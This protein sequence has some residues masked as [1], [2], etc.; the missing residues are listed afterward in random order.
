MDDAGERKT[1][2]A[3][4]DLLDAGRAAALESF[5]ESLG[6][7]ETARAVARL[8]EENREKLF[9]LL[10]PDEAAA[11]ILDLP[12]AQAAEVIEDM[13][14]QSA[15]LIV[16]HLPDNERADVLGDIPEGSA[17]AI[18]DRM[19]TKDAAEARTLMDYPDNTAGGLMTR[20]YLAYGE[21]MTAADVVA[22][23]RAQRDR[24]ASHD[25][26][27]IYVLAPGGRLAG[28]LRLRDLLLARPERAIG[29]AM[30][31]T[32]VA[33]PADA[34][35]ESVHALLHDQG[36]LGLP[37][38]DRQGQLLGV[39]S[40][41]KL[42]EAE[43]Q[44][45]QHAMLAMSG[46]VGGEEL[47]SMPLRR[48]AGKRLAWLSL[49]VLL[50]I[51]AASVIAVYQ[52]TLSAAVVLAVFL[53]IISD[54]SGCSGNQAAAVSIREL[55][56]GLVRPGE[57]GRVLLKE[58]AVG[59]VN[60]LLLGGMLSAATILWRG[61]PYLGLVVGLSLAVN[62]AVSACLGGLLPLALRRLRMDPALASGPILTTV[63]DM[64]GFFLVLKLA[65]V[66]LPRLTS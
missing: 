44:R 4:T 21:G 49:N 14:P 33:V 28:I 8:S 48:R 36:D 6:P 1:W 61:N 39:V 13:D 26:P 23:I 32:F 40:R 66:L 63:T 60:G 18:L 47:R 34:A 59:T 57:L 19:S 2:D 37:V 56:L 45:D 38:V 7:T 64:C 41:D 30:T 58:A 22:D 46:I 54:M 5:L 35:L 10:S 52:D 53:P 16:S 42:L 50:N 15:A 51:A 11:V 12:D 31:R 65:T 55:S 9:R 43:G 17:S 62:T 20:A 27:C 24:Y 25:T 29:E 3:I